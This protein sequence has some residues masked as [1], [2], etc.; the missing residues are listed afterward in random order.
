MIDMRPFRYG[1]DVEKRVWLHQQIGH[2]RIRRWV[3]GHPA[4]SRC[5][6]VTVG[7]L[8]DGRHFADHS[9]QQGAIVCADE[10]EARRLAAE[11]TSGDGWTETP[12]N[13]DARE[14]PLDAHRWRRVGG[15]WVLNEADA[16]T[17]G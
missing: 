5:A 12:A 13:L 11:W 1:D 14:Q 10:A 6:Y 16:P 3:Y 8:S 2:R 4:S 17:T 15:T 9:R 7:T